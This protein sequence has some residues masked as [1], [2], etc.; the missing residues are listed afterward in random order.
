MVYRQKSDTIVIFVLICAKIKNI[1]ATGW[2]MNDV[3]ELLKELKNEVRFL[4]VNIFCA[5]I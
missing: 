2:I 1:V 4:V 3:A 5:Y